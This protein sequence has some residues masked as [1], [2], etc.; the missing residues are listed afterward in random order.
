MA[1]RMGTNAP[2]L[3]HPHLTPRP[4]FAGLHADF[5]FTIDLCAA[6]KKVALLPRFFSRTQNALKQDWQPERGF[7]DCPFA[8]GSTRL[9]CLRFCQRVSTADRGQT[10]RETTIAGGRWAARV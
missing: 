10:N 9:A 6:S 1:L 4:I 5:E 3:S 7:C 2:I 8:R